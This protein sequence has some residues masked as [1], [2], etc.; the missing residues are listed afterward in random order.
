MSFAEYTKNYLKNKKDKSKETSTNNQKRYT[1]FAD[2]TES[3]MQE[4]ANRNIGSYIDDFVNDASSFLSD[5]VDVYS[6]VGFSNSKAEYVARNSQQ[7]NLNSR[8]NRIRK[9]LEENEVDEAVKKEITDY[10][11]AY[12]LDSNNIVDAFK[13]KS[14]YFSQWEN[15]DAYNYWYDT[16]ESKKKYAAMTNEEIDAEIERLNSADYKSGR[17]VTKIIGGVGDVV[18]ELKGDTE[19]DA[20]KKFQDTIS[21][22]DYTKSESALQFLQNERLKRKYEEIDTSPEEVNALME[23]YTELE[24][25]LDEEKIKNFGA[26]W[27]AAFNRNPLSTSAYSPDLSIEPRMKEI[28]DKL[29]ALHPDWNVLVE[30][31]RIRRDEEYYKPFI[32][33]LQ[34]EAEEAPVLSSTASVIMSPLKVWGTLGMVDNAFDDTELPMNPNS[35]WYLVNNMVNTPREA[36]MEN[37]DWVDSNGKDWFDTLYS[38]GMSTADS[39]FTTAVT[40][41][42]SWAGGAVLGISAASDTAQQV[43]LNGGT[44]EQAL[45]TGLFA[46][47]NEMLWEK[48]SLGNFNALTEK[49]IRNIFSKKGIK[50][51]IGN[52]LK[53]AGVNFSEEATTE[54]SNLI[55]DYLVN[56][57]ASSYAQAYEM[58]RSAGYNSSEARSKA[59]DYM[60]K[61]VAEAG[62]S[63]A[64]QGLFMGG[65]GTSI[66]SSLNTVAVNEA[67]KNMSE[68]DIVALQ[69]QARTLGVDV[70]DIDVG[71]AGPWGGSASAK[72]VANLISAVQDKQ[73]QT[74]R[75]KV[76]D[77][78]KSY[79]LNVSLYNTQ[80]ETGFNKLKK[81]VANIEREITARINDQ[82]D[83]I[84][85]SALAD[86]I[87]E[88]GESR[89]KALYI[90]DSYIRA[91][92]GQSLDQ[93]RE[94]SLNSE[95][96]RIAI[97]EFNSSGENTPQ[98][99]LEAKQQIENVYAEAERRYITPAHSDTAET[100]NVKSNVE[101]TK[102]G[103]DNIPDTKNITQNHKA[104]AVVNGKSVEVEGIGTV[105]EN[106]A[107]VVVNGREV[108][109]KN[110]TF[111]NP[112][113]EAA[114]KFASGMDT[115]EK[116]KAALELYNP[117]FDNGSDYKTAFNEY[118]N[119]GIKGIGTFNDIDKYYTFAHSFPESWR[120]AVFNAGRSNKIYKSGVNKLYKTRNLSKIQKSQL[121]VLDLLGEKYGISFLVFDN[122][123]DSDGDL[124]GLQIAGTNKVAVS[125]EAD[126]KLYLRTAGHEC[127]HIIEE[128]NP[129][130]ATELTEKVINYLKQTEGYNYTEQVQEYGRR[131]G[132]DANT[133]EGLALIHS[134][135]AADSMF[136]VFSNE[137]FIKS[138]VTENRTLAQKIKDFLTD[139]I[140]EL[141]E[142]ITHFHA[143]EEMNALRKQT[144]VLED[145]NASFI[146]ALE[147]ATK[148]MQETLSDKTKNTA[149]KDGVRYSIKK[150]SKMP[151]ANQIEQIENQQLNGSNSLYIGIPSAQLQS[152]GFSNNPFAMN[153]SDYRKS[154]RKSSPNKNYSKHAV[155][156]K[157]FEQLPQKLNEA[158]M[159]IDNGKKVTVV[160]DNL[161]ID[162]NGNPSYI[163]AGVWKN[164]PMDDGYINQIKSV[165]PLDDFIKRI[166]ES[167]ESGNL[168]II[169]KNKA[170]DL[171]A[172]IGIQPSQRSRIIN[173]AK[174]SISQY[175]EKSS[176]IDNQ[177]FEAVECGDM[178]TAQKLVEQVA[179]E[180]GYDSPL[181]YHGTLNFGFTEFDISK[182]FIF[183][184]SDNA[185]VSTYSAV[186]GSRSLT[187]LKYN[188]D[189]NPENDIRRGNYALYAKL[190][191]SLVLDCERKNYE[192]LFNIKSNLVE[193][194]ENTELIKELEKLHVTDDMARL[195]KAYGYDSVV[196]KNI[197]DT[198]HFSYSEM[199]GD[200]YVLFD[201]S[202][203]KSADTVTYDG[204]GNIIPLSQRFNED[205]KDIRR[206]IK[207][208]QKAQQVLDENPELKNAFQNL[209][210]ELGLTKGFVPEG[211][212]IHKYA[213]QL[214][215][216]NP[217]NVSV[218]EIESDL[219]EIYSVLSS[220]SG[221]E[222]YEYAADLT[223]NLAKKML[224][225]SRVL[226]DLNAEKKELRQRLTSAVKGYKWYLSPEMRSEI[227]YHY[228][229]YGNFHKKIFGKGFSFSENS[230]DY[231]DSDW[232]ELC[233]AVPELFNSD[234]PA[235]EQPL[236][237]LEAFSA[238]E[239]EYG[240]FDDY[241]YD[242]Q[243]KYIATDI[244]NNLAAVPEADTLIGKMK[245]SEYDR[246]AK[247]KSE[248]AEKIN[249]LKKK[250]A[251]E[252]ERTAAEEKT[253]YKLQIKQ[254]IESEKATKARK[255][256]E[257][258]MVRLS[259]MLANGTKSRHIPLKL[260]DTVRELCYSI[261]LNRASQAQLGDNLNK[262]EAL[263]AALNQGKDDVNGETNNQFL[264]NAYDEYVHNLIHQLSE[265]LRHKSIGS[266][267]LE[268]L[269]LVDETVKAVAQ[270]VA[271]GNELH[272]ESRNEGVEETAQAISGELGTAKVKRLYKSDKLNNA[273]DKIDHEKWKFLKPVYAWRMIG[274]DTFAEL[275]NN[276]RKGE[277]T[278]AVDIAEAREK[279]LSIS[280][281]YHKDT[282]A[283]DKKVLTLASGDK[284]T[285]SVQQ[286]MM[287][288]VASQRE[289]YIPHLIGH[290]RGKNGD[291]VKGGFV[292]EDA[293][294][295]IEDRKGNYKGAKVRAWRKRDAGTHHL[296]GSDL[297]LFAETLTPEQ[298]AYANEMRDYLA[299]GLAVK[300]N[301]ITRKLYDMNKFVEDKYFPIKV[302]REFLDG[303]MKE[304]EV[305]S[306]LSTSI[307]KDLQEYANNP[308]LLR[309]FDDM[310]AE[311]VQQMAMFHSFALPLDDFTRVFNY[312]SSNGS[313]ASIKSRIETACGKGAVSYIENFIK[314]VNGGVHASSTPT[315]MNKALSLFKKGAVFASAS[316]AIQQPSAIAR[317]LAVVDT[318]YFA[319]TTFT[320]RDYDELMKYAPIARVKSMGFFDNSI[321]QS[322]KEWLL[323]REYKGLKNKAVALLKDSSFRDDVLSAAPE[324]MDEITWCHLWNAVK[325]ETAD[326]YN[327]TGESLLKKS[328]E[329]FSEVVELTQVYDSVFSK[330]EYMRSKD[331]GAKMS[332]AFMAE[333]TTALNMLVDAAANLKHG[334]KKQGARFVGAFV[335]SV[336]FNN[337]LKSLVT[338]ARDDDEEKT[339]VE[340]YLSA[341]SSGILNDLNPLTLL[342]W[343]KDIVSIFSGYSVERADMSLVQ[344]L[345]NAVNSL[346]SDE[347]SNYRKIEDT[348]GALAAFLGLPVKNVMRDFRAA[349]NVCAG[350]FGFE[351]ENEDG[352]KV[353]VQKNIKETSGEGIKNA[354]TDEFS[355]GF[356]NKVKDFMEEKLFGTAD[357]QLYNAIKQGNYKAYEKL[358]KEE[359]EGDSEKVNSA[360]RNGLINYD[361][362]ITKAA[363]ARRDGNATLYSQCVNG[364][365]ADGFSNE[366]IR[367]AVDKVY[368]ELTDDGEGTETTEKAY[369]LYT[370]EDLN[371]AIE[372]GGDV[373]S[374]IDDITSAALKNGK[375]EEKARESIR[376]QVTSYWKPLYLEASDYE[377]EE[378]KKLLD[379][380]ELYSD[381]DDTLYGWEKDYTTEKYK[382]LYLEA[383]RTEKER[384]ISELE[385]T[386]LYSD[387]AKT[388]R[389]W[390]V[391]V[392]KEEYKAAT[393]QTE[394]ERIKAEIWNTGYYKYYSN[395]S[396][397]LDKL[398]ADE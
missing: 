139:L 218:A 249:E 283:D 386:G 105:S 130:A 248:N 86:R 164:Q 7:K 350:I 132:V 172:P 78:A 148:N 94:A 107:T 371:N 171:L 255:S 12:D 76:I 380:T 396:K 309:D 346:G 62:F 112:S 284:F 37:Y 229:S 50:T 213:A 10:L 328:G 372:T 258:T 342:P 1:S 376:N 237:I 298:K 81:S 251:E 362:R 44:K 23:E 110:I 15:E 275:M 221:S 160:T 318:K 95:T 240:L 321:G 49:G 269:I 73:A 41:G 299:K 48:I 197:E 16:E 209:Q 246:I 333:P 365:S 165:Y 92:D 173:L 21:S 129:E 178:E 137:K 179:K 54:A 27:G 68:A 367:K 277:D 393:S 146:S 39:L 304:P 334:N 36:V 348:A 60:L 306:V 378:I 175:S 392:L 316:V 345:Y 313:P 387:A 377:Q 274:S 310:W 295:V 182:G 358:L 22:S 332:M 100:V 84:Y 181:L 128:W 294:K 215:K 65:A 323:S 157:F 43:A 282:W 224:D 368:N 64:L 289:Q 303:N 211:K 243:A 305:R 4:K 302:A 8:A 156:R 104:S 116:A 278:W 312:R 357:E 72:K 67:T 261:T 87:Q 331:T 79:G 281:K 253:H 47:V 194:E 134:E 330:S 70:S 292:F 191:K 161:M 301:E 25:R 311:H 153:Q 26:Y 388:A 56:G 13:S 287:L 270:R 24:R 308:I 263:Y 354:I 288:Y 235:V 103:I 35:P 142:M 329:R 122:L 250:Y 210:N 216:D 140:S 268:E 202:D 340:K 20:Y 349:F 254:K 167:A 80:T 190:G 398:D 90:A 96:A 74:D 159:F 241:Q 207:L 257:I 52:I 276:I 180:N 344:D 106:G 198:G 230:T 42:S 61:Q 252:I 91:V 242:T 374:I 11:D 184:T 214:K 99:V 29:N 315:V 169:N 5:S 113:A 51:A 102:K 379:N 83:Y 259:G 199:V 217:S 227:E 347:K 38:T 327:L 266:M 245:S 193:S 208:T 59:R 127:F 3:Y 85:I 351:K 200:V 133:N 236:V 296:T 66:G 9:F 126:G 385:D 285:F 109:I 188:Q 174:D 373:Q 360:I 166:T 53:S 265:Q 232:S 205:N 138:L 324:K 147:A 273:S 247:L 75:Q 382:P 370:Y 187:D 158:V 233:A 369:S 394:R 150:T 18:S 203:V 117:K 97:N 123:K 326:K 131:Y 366:N 135:M 391:A 149:T 222:G 272:I 375:T 119:A 45:I 57:G 19:S 33:T 228:D 152:A 317:A 40:G 30:Y 262:I 286:L 339:L 383:S 352:E 338:A 234:T 55:V 267:T 212:T 88:L 120:E 335:A 244:M 225:S 118:Y 143:S 151:Y 124:S 260:I 125:L 220:M 141:R 170:N 162:T 361:E 82:A 384:I 363:E 322:T 155:K 390:E 355:E 314:D 206:S 201:S 186:D 71:S 63:G 341:V 136:D 291:T 115:T 6:N 219:R 154:R 279:V 297:D 28:E 46:G 256:I 177:Y 34:K 343:V 176:E 290:K 2:Y 93:Y 192:N 238:T 98:W 89:G 325:A 226:D 69:E 195:A 111:N 121:K 356:L 389:G 359:Y 31:N 58:Y 300:G 77:T 108:D 293:Y 17:L 320:K 364:L 231:L 319:K 264:K 204:D 145:I 163:V 307:M 223:L 280:E 114:Y 381:L 144:V 101:S 271:R 196:F 336:I 353:P 239:Y 185:L 14:E 395:M 189:D 32:E 168:V 337:I 183:A 397:A